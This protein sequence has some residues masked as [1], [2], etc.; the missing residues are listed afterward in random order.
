MGAGAPDLHERVMAY[1]GSTPRRDGAY[2]LALVPCRS[3]CPRMTL[4]AVA[5]LPGLRG[6]APPSPSSAA[7]AGAHLACGGWRP[8]GP[9]R[10]SGAHDCPL[11]SAA[12][13]RRHAQNHGDGAVWNRICAVMTRPG[14]SPAVLL[15]SMCIV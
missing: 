2:A 15:R 3:R 9:Q 4:A 8:R 13:V 12:P 6:L 10:M 7:L 11:A 5:G 1:G 14:G